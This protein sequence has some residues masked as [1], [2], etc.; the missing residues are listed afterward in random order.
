MGTAFGAQPRYLAIAQQ[1]ADEIRD[2]VYPPKSKLPSRAEIAAT[3]GVTS[4]TAS[5]AVRV[6]I[7]QGLAYGI[8]GSGTFVRQQPVVQRVVRTPGWRYVDGTT[9]EVEVAGA[10]RNHETRFRIPCPPDVAGR[11]DIAPGAPCTRTDYL[12]H[13]PGAYGLPRAVALSTSWEPYAVTEGSPVLAPEDGPLAGRG[14]VERMAAIG[15]DITSCQEEGGTRPASPEEA[16]KLDMPEGVWLV[17]ICR[18]YIGL[19]DGMPVP[20]ETADIRYPGDQYRVTYDV[21]VPRS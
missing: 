7:S 21:P 4:Q 12:F 5:E 19:V 16:T 11:L 3:H 10:A 18:T 20:V 17:T 2:G 6:L 1:L 9:A 13:V 14:V 15:S 8:A